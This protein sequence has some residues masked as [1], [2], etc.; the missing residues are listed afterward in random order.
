LNQPIIAISRYKFVNVLR[1]A[2]DLLV[3]G[4]NP[5]P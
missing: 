4:S 2:Q 3:A 5:R 1:R